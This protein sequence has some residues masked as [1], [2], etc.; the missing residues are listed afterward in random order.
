M[1]TSSMPRTILLALLATCGAALL[2]AA[3]ARAGN[4]TVRLGSTSGSHWSTY[5]S[6]PFLVTPGRVAS[7][8]GVFAPGN[9]RSW[10]AQVVGS[11]SRIVGG[12]IRVGV[13]TPNAGM[14]GRL[15][16]G[17]GNVPVVVHEE[18]GTGAVERS[19]PGGPH[20][21]VQFDIS[22]TAALTTTGSGQDHVDLQFVDLVLR[23]SVP[24]TAEVLALAPPATWHDATTCIPFTMR[25]TDQGGGL[26]RVQV[27]R[28]SDGLVIAAQDSPMA[29]SPKP[30]AGE[31]TLADCI[32]P[33]ER[34]HGDTSFQ[35]TAWDVSGAV[36]ELGFSVRADHVA[37]NVA[38]GP[39]AGA[40]LGTATPVVA[41]EVSDQGAGLASV[42]ATID[43]ASRAVVFANGVATVQAG[44]LAIGPHVVA[45]TATDA[46]G[47]ATNVERRF[48]VADAQPPTLQVTSPGARGGGAVDVRVAA[49][50]ELSG[51]DPHGW[52]LVV[53]GDPHPFDATA[54]HLAARVT[55]LADGM[56]R[57]EV[58]A[59]DRA[60][61]R[62]T[63]SHDYYV[64]P[65]APVAA[66]APGRSGLSL[67]DA[68]RSS[69]AFGRAATVALHLVREGR[70][71][72]GHR[73]TA[74]RDGTEVAAAV[75]D[76]DGIARI[77]VPASRP[78]RF[79]A[80]AEGMGYEAVVLPLRVAPRVV[81]S[82]SA[83]RPRVGERV[84]LA[85][86]LFPALRG[87]TISV[88][89]RV[90]G[91]W[92]PIRRITRTDPAGR[93]ATSVVGATP[94]PIHVRV[95]VKPAGSW[96]GA[97]SNARLLQVRR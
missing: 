77:A 85:G 64:V 83:T 13:T 49:T 43:G 14:R 57:I 95:K 6:G 8:K 4:Y 3:P 42:A 71:V 61:N 68:P 47:N 1:Q 52:Q 29:E 78:G 44:R 93:F 96:A 25:F 90:G 79:E 94:G 23:D 40:R 28:A 74:L 89:A 27:R 2:L 10:R 19:I 92:F 31:L 87:R 86:R 82:T 80:I 84:R 7:G 45:I 16:V 73:V 63:V 50:D 22:S 18:F 62:S 17:T 21:W 12:T 51:V 54:E 59:H 58:V 24:P 53:D 56:H 37:P 26:R 81:V 65:A 55:G 5:G 66:A 76:A 67:V 34:W 35:A 33:G 72:D 32:H 91:V 60:G 88:E 46:A 70:A 11:G 30:G 41:F 39:V 20:D 15:V 36:R 75:T 97:I 38:G 48:E 9:Y 69:V